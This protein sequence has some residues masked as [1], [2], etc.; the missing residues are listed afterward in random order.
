MTTKNKH[1]H[2]DCEHNIKFCA[3]CNEAYCLKCEAVWSSKPCAQ[4]HYPY[5]YQPYWT[6]TSPIT[7]TTT[8]GTVAMHSLC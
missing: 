7:V 3:P 1:T 8:S 6:P 5:Y 2:H 4:N